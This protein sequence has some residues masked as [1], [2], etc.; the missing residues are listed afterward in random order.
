MNELWGVPVLVTGGAGFVGSSLV[1][2]L[3]LDGAR[4]TV[5]DDFTTGLRAAL[6]PEG[7]TVVEGSVVDMDVVKRLVADAEV[8]FH[9]A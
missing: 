2:R 7:I 3:V 5:L 6:P 8:V 9:L 4:V 1:R